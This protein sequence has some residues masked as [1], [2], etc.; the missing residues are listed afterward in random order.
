MVN[1][2]NAKEDVMWLV[3]HGQRSPEDLTGTYQLPG[4]TTVIS[5]DVTYSTVLSLDNLLWGLLIG[6]G[7]HKGHRQ[8]QEQQLLWVPHPDFHPSKC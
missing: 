8:R 1:G 4:L 7:Q 2:R 3:A 6:D 5:Q